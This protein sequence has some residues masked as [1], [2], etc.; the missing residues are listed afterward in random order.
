LKDV[1]PE[2]PGWLR[3]VPLPAK[4]RGGAPVR[5]ALIEDVPSL[6]W[7]V[8]YGCIDLHVW[9]ARADRPDR[10]DHV[11]FDLDPA[12]VAFA[13]VVRAALLLRE[14]LDALELASHVK[15]TGGRGLHVHVPIARRHTHSEARGFAE[16]LAAAL[17]RASRGLVTTER[18]PARR[19]GVYV[20]TK[21]NGRGQQV[22]SAYSLRPLPGAPV[23]T[24]LRWEELDE[25]LDPA[26]LT[27]DVVLGRL[28][29]HGDLLAP[30]LRSRQLLSS[31]LAR[32]A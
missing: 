14:A 22:V 10:P 17:A 29:E 27:M 21:M 7:A 32:L 20:D 11:L 24:P 6:A 31:A 25:R 9:T 23:A 30:A 26:A 3:V 16:T 1:P 13:D 28:A 5:Y 4:S 18:S 15:T 12:E 8:D 19:R 2:A